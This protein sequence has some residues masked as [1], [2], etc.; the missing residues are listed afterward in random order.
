MNVTFPL[1]LLA[2]SHMAA[3]WSGHRVDCSSGKLLLLCLSHFPRVHLW[4]SRPCS[5]LE[6]TVF[7]LCWDESKSLYLVCHLDF[8]PF[9]ILCGGIVWKNKCDTVSSLIKRT[10]MAAYCSF[11]KVRNTISY[12]ALRS[13]DTYHLHLVLSCICLKT[14]EL[15]ILFHVRGAEHWCSRHEYS[16]SS[17]LWFVDWS[18]HIV[19]SDEKT[20]LQN[21]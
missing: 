21:K 10:S 18:V 6:P 7:T 14:V 15:A 2:W 4:S 3:C 20:K 5:I 19:Y 1:G 13:Q 8:Q 9:S 17:T 12:R 16:S 11:D